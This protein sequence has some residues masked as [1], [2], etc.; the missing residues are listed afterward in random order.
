MI[1]HEVLA[2]D[3]LFKGITL[4]SSMTTKLYEKKLSQSLF[5]FVSLEK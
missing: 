5:D 2:S 3:I 1:I 4:T